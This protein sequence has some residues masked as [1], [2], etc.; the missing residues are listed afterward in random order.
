MA[1]SGW[2]LASQIIGYAAQYKQ[3]KVNYQAQIDTYFDRVSTANSN[4]AII[5]IGRAHV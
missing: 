1:V 3:N 5:K 2:F 4:I